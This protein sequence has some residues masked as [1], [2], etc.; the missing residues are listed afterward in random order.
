NAKQ[1]AKTQAKAA[2]GKK[3]GKGP[4]K[5]APPQ[6]F[7]AWS[8]QTLERLVASEPEPLVSRMRVTHSMVL[9]VIARGERHEGDALET[10]RSLIF[11]S[12]EPR[13][14]QFEHARAAIGI[15]RT[16]RQGGIVE[17]RDGLLGLTVELQSNFALNQ[18]LSPFALAAI[19]LLDPES[20]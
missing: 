7:V 20:P 15:F 18:P 11:D 5:K 4:K 1:S 6:G 9:S 13:A 12:H 14:A 19:E 16:L 17:R 3:V 2:A 10:M 8:E